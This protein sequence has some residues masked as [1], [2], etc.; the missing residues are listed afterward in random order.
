[1]I[2]AGEHAFA[3]RFLPLQLGA[4]MAAHIEK[5]AERARVVPRQQHR[6]THY[7][8]RQKTPLF[9]QLLRPGRHDRTS[10]KDRRALALE[11]LL[12]GVAADRRMR[13]CVVQI[14]PLLL[15]QTDD[16]LDQ[17]DFFF[18]IQVVLPNEIHSGR[19]RRRLLTDW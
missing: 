15:R 4:A 8:P 18:A 10:A 11:S 19:S 17:T 6:Q 7:V 14:R 5:G 1:M 9:G 2:G 12:A 3:A 16:L 13:D